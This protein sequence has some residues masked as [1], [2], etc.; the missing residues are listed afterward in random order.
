VDFP[1]NLGSPSGH[2]CAKCARGLTGS[3]GVFGIAI[4]T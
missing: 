4:R 2:Y 1:L 3:E